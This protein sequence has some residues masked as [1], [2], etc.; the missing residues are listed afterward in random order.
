MNCRNELIVCGHIN[1]KNNNK[2]NKNKE[3]KKIISDIRN[4]VKLTDEVLN[5]IK[6]LSEKEKME[7]I[8][9]YDKTVQIIKEKIDDLV[10]YKN[11]R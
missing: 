8:I 9:E 6:L 5:F 4:N 2:T 7:I 3:F 11:L 10:N 1:N